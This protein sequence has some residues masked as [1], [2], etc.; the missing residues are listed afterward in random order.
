[1]KRN[2]NLFG[3]GTLSLIAILI[4][5]FAPGA[6][7]AA[8]A[9]LKSNVFNPSILTGPLTLCVGSPAVNTGGNNLPTCQNLCDFLVQVAQVIYFA[10][11]VVIWII[12]PILVAIG[13]LMILLAGAS[14]ELVS[15]GKKTITGAI[16]GMVIVLCAW[17]IVFTFVNAFGG[18]SRYVGGFGGNGGNIEC[19]V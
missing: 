14:P 5:I 16:W 1:M 2:L 12:V 19:T 8:T 17:L 15:R 9:A 13:G 6:A 4:P 7:M 3:L 10:I 18:L 11:G